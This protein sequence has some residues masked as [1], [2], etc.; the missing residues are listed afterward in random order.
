MKIINRKIGQIILL[1][2]LLVG[3][4]GLKALLI[5]IEIDNE[6]RQ[7]LEWTPETVSL[8]LI[9]QPDGT[10]IE[11]ERI[12]GGELWIQAIFQKNGYTLVY[13]NTSQYWCWAYLGE[14]GW[15]LPTEFPIHLYD[16]EVLG[17]EKN[18]RMCPSFVEEFRKLRLDVTPRGFRF[19]SE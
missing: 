15:L 6:N 16:P 1:L 5:P 9:T 12:E 18:I 10:E 4:S 13:D 8:R 2:I 19:V 14:C 17:L 3:M 7:P 11:I